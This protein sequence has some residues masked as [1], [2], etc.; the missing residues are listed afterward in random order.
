MNSVTKV[1]EQVNELPIFEAVLYGNKLIYTEKDGRALC[2][3]DVDGSNRIELVAEDAFAISVVDG[4]IF[5]HDYEYQKRVRVDG[6]GLEVL[7]TQI[8][9]N[10]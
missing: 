7:K 10:K 2:L 4:W 9:E 3:S 8:E 5:F 6:T 1:T